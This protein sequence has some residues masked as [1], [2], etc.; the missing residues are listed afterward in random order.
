MDLMSVCWTLGWSWLPSLGLIWPWLTGLFS[1][2]HFREAAAC[3]Y[4]V[5]LNSWLA[6]YRATCPCFFLA[7]LQ[8][9]DHSTLQ[10]PLCVLFCLIFCS[11]LLSPHHWICP[12]VSDLGAAWVDTYGYLCSPCSLLPTFKSLHPSWKCM[13]LHTNGYLISSKLKLSGWIVSGNDLGINQC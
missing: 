4:L 3:A 9:K 8:E 12:L 1:L 5:M 6:L 11:L 7:E 13:S 10:T 2:L